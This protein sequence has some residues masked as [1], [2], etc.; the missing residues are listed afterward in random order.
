M[1]VTTPDGHVGVATTTVTVALD[2]RQTIYISSNGSDSNS[3]LSANSPI[4]TVDHLDQIMQSNERVL[5]QAGGTYDLNTHGIELNGLQHMYVGSYGTG[6]AP[7]LMYTG[8]AP[9]TSRWSSWIKR[10]NPS[11]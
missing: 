5:F 11:S 2:N 8:A 6:A 3:G 10:R 7:I 4:Q 1:R 9:A